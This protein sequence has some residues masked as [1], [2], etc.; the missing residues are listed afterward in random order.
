MPSPQNIAKAPN[1]ANFFATALLKDSGVGQGGLDVVWRLT[2]DSVGNTLKPS[3]PQVVAK[4]RI[5]LTKG[6]PVRVAWPCG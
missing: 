1:A 3:K 6:H 5:S 2:Y 4:Y